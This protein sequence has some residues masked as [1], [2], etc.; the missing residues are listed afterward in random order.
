MSV[1]RKSE[2]IVAVDTREQMPLNLEK[3]G[4][5]SERPTLAHGDYSLFYPDLRHYL[6][7]ERKSLQDFVMCATTEQSMFEKE[8][9]ALRGYNYKFV[10]CEFRL[11]DI[12]NHAYRSNNEVDAIMGTL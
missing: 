9:L 12:T 8:L 11:Q 5:K 3:Y 6:T 2:I 7:I 4:L 10:V 1:S